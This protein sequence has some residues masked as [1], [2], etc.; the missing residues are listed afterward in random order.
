[1]QR[2]A[3]LGSV[4]AGSVAVLAG[5]A[6]PLLGDVVQEE[7]EWS[8]LPSD[9]GWPVSVHNENG[10][11]AVSTHNGQ[12]V[13]V[14]ALVTAPSE[15]RLGDVRSTATRQTASSWWPFGWT[16]IQVA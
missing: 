2:R 13:V 7:R 6:G 3:L 16:A 8:F 15:E 11:V 14:D 4:A 5:C 10:D 1:M 9:D 12:R